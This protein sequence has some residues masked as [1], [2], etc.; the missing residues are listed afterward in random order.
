ML[1]G[2]LKQMEG[3]DVGKH[4]LVLKLIQGI[5]N[6]TAPSGILPVPPSTLYLQAHAEQRF[7][8]WYWEYARGGTPRRF[9]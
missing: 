2:T 1:S 4:P 3:Y 8:G 9:A 5:F 7:S 6:S